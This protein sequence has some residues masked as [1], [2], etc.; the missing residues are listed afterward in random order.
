ML[1]ILVGYAIA[2]LSSIAL[3]SSK[4]M[5][6]LEDKIPALYWIGWLDFVDTCKPYACDTCPFATENKE[7]GYGANSADPSEGYY[8]CGLLNKKVWG[9]N[10]DCTSENWREEIKKEVLQIASYEIQSLIKREVI[11]AAIKDKKSEIVKCMG[12]PDIKVYE[13]E[14]MFDRFLKYLESEEG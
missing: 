4:T 11:I 9:E 7:D 1:E 8:N 5:P 12:H 14:M 6:S 2:T 13:F 10:P 3:Q